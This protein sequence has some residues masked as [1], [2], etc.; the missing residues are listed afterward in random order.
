[1]SDSYS[2]LILPGDGI[3]PEVMAEVVKVIDWFQAHR[4]MRFEVSQGLVGGGA[5]PR[6][7]GGSAPSPPPRSRPAPAGLP[8]RPAPPP[9]PPPA[10]AASP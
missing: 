2:L 10:R 8:A 1:M 5:P 7:R 4:G 6:P 3:G 9:S